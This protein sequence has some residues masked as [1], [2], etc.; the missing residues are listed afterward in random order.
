MAAICLSK[1]D[2]DYVMAP[3]LE[4]GLNSMQFSR[5]FSRSIVYG[6]KTVQ[7]LGLKDPYIVQGL[8]WIQILMRHGDRDTVTGQ[9]L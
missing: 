2:W 7:G 9:L 8:T 6:P 1:K 5:N 3:V 4:A